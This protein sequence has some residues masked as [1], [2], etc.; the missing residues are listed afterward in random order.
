MILREGYL[1]KYFSC[2]ESSKYITC[3]YTNMGAVD[4]RLLLQEQGETQAKSNKQK[5]WMRC[6]LP[7]PATLSFMHASCFPGRVSFQGGVFFFGCCSL[8]LL[9]PNCNFSLLETSDLIQY[10]TLLVTVKCYFS[11]G[12]R[13]V[14]LFR[15]SNIQHK[16]INF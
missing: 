6:H 1:Y 8:P 9:I 4:G 11:S 16:R 3:N 14:R 2:T 7:T 5:V 12:Y 10:F 13:D 15:Q